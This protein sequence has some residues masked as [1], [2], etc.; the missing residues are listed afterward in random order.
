MADSP[1]IPYADAGR[2]G[3]MKYDIKIAGRGTYGDHHHPSGL[4]TAIF[5][6][7]V[8]LVSASTH[9]Q[10]E[11]RPDLES[12]WLGKLITFDDPRWSIEDVLCNQW[13]TLE[14]LEYIGALLA[15]SANDKLSIAELLEQGSQF[16]S[17]YISSLLT[18]VA[19]E[20][21]MQFDQ[22]DDPVNECAP[23]GFFVQAVGQPLPIKIQQF[24]DRV[25]FRYEYWDVVRIVY[26]D[27]RDH[28]EALAPSLYGHSIGW[29]DGPTLVVETRGIEPNL[30][31]VLEIDGLANTEQVVSIE[32]YTRSEDGNQLNTIL[33]IVDPM[34]LREPMVSKSSYLSFPGMEF[35][36]YDCKAVS[37]EF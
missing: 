23:P 12:T 5:A 15:D 33:T 20:Q 19:V 9:A 16:N 10:Q 25:E 18:T 27:G 1:H 34:M 30:Y 6:S 31:A 13:C 29:Y 37:G 35:Q 17:A 2:T 36:K 11:G 28:P 14:Q 24:D 7:V 21:Q 22:T 32:R 4:L 8:L 26:T 3:T